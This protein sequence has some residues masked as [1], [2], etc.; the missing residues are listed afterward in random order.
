MT[1]YKADD[2]RRD[3]QVRFW[4]KVLVPEAGC[5]EWTGTLRTNG[6]GLIHWRGGGQS[7]HRLS[8]GFFNGP[9]PEGKMVLHHCDNPPCVN[10]DHLYLGGNRE[11]TM[12]RERRG[13]GTA[14]LT[15][16]EVRDIRKRAATGERQIDLG[17]EYGVVRSAI[18][19]IVLRKK[20]IW[21]D[22]G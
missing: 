14:K 13:R 19:D 16:D 3:E 22:E 17:R 1:S 2:P 7:A 18:S 20:W 4:N 15:P 6:Y 12:D 21:V 8:F 11:N 10:P 5:W 9:I